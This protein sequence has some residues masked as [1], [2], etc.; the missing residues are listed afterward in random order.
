MLNLDRVKKV[1][2]VYKILRYLVDR[3]H[4]NIFYRKVEFT[5]LDNFDHTK[6]TLI[7]P[8][9]Q[10]AL[11]DPL[12]VLASVPYTAPVFLA[13]QDI[14]KSKLLGNFF[15]GI[16]MLPVF[17]I[18]DGAETLGKNEEIFERCA[19]LLELK[20]TVVIFPEAQHTCY[21]SVLQLKK[22]VMRVAFR[23]AERTNFDID[24]QIV[25]A[26]IYY[27]SYTPYRTILLVN[28]GKPVFIKDYA[29]LYAQNQQAAMLQLRD[30]LRERILPLAIHIKNMEFYEVY[31]NSRDLFDFYYAQINSLNLNKPS[32]KF[33]ADKFIIDDLD[34]LHVADKIKF[35]QLA[36]DIRDYF[37]E[38]KS[39]KLKDYLFDK[40]VSFT[41][42]L[43]QTLM[44]IFLLPL[45]IAGFINFA[46]PLLLP[47]LLVKKFK[48]QQFHS[49]VRYVAS[50]L[51]IPLWAIIGFAFLWIFVKVWWIKFVFLF[52]QYP[53][54][55]WWL[56]LR[57]WFKKIAG[58]WRFIF[59]GKKVADLRTRR[60]VIIQKV[61]N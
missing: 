1:G 32:D 4:N 22:G 44:W 27:E 10:N 3:Y 5:G 46:I 54:F 55:V 11:M 51:L 41:L 39:L 34:N 37:A 45:N 31:E 8:N 47:E 49:S 50:L 59:K 36:D 24:L 13:R 6:A 14:F 2:F 48:D 17:R 33:K 53:L 12:A 7:G 23:A 9:H 40:K 29:E 42:T 20:R 61:V 16:N 15:T 30:D 58:K 18:R 60:K 52:M 25:P 28:Y 57:R 43:L 56:E 26:G 21:R 38:L 19:E 35:Q